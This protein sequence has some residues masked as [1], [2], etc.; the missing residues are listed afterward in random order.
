MFQRKNDNQ[1]L[2]QVIKK[3][4][5]TSCISSY[6][7][8]QKESTGKKMDKP[9]KFQPFIDIIKHPP[10][11]IHITQKQKHQTAVYLSPNVAA[12]FQKHCPKTKTPNCCPS[13]TKCC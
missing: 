5:L 7:T 13:F 1:R 11:F 12:N 8:K 2:K 4:V 3:M 6:R 9:Q 10:T